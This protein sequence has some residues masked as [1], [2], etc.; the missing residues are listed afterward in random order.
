M[1]KK[2]FNQNNQHEL[3][4]IFYTLS[5]CSSLGFENETCHKIKLINKGPLPN[6]AF[7]Y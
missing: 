1:N 5:E 2:T 6:F 3:I 7:K 4:I